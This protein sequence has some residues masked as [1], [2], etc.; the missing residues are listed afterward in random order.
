MEA[1]SVV[2]LVVVVVSEVVSEVASVA[3]SVAGL[4]PL[5][6]PGISRTKTCM[7]TTLDRTNLLLMEV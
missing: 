5:V 6:Q 1:L 7:P 2:A 3:A 4:H